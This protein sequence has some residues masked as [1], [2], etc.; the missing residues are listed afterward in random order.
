MSDRW[1][2]KACLHIERTRGFFSTQKFLE[3][4]RLR[5]ISRILD[6]EVFF[7]VSCR[8]ISSPEYFLAPSVYDATTRWFLEKLLGFFSLFSVEKG[9]W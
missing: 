8:R 7:S 6:S 9:F 4:N 5:I 2:V 3:K 1:R